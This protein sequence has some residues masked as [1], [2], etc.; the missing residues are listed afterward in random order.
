ML[1]TLTENK[2]PALTV[3]KARQLG[4]DSA[5]YGLLPPTPWW[6]GRQGRL[7]GRYRVAAARHIDCPCA[8]RGV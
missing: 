8:M 5:A 4:H 6:P 7:V 2:S 3:D 1:W